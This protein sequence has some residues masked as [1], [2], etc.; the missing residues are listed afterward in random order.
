MLS[1]PV[2]TVLTGGLRT[3][4]R[5]ASSHLWALESVC[6]QRAFLSQ[7][8]F[9][10]ERPSLCPSSSL[11]TNNITQGLASATAEQDCK[12]LPGLTL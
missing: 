5:V 7:L 11:G 6:S 9:L 10:L 8:Y 4:D 3:W 1:V 12:G 2:Y